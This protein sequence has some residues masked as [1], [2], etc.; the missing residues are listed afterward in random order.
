MNQ[1]QYIQSLHKSGKRFVIISALLMLAVPL[2]FSIVYNAWPTTALMI[3]GFMSVGA[4]YIPIGIIETYN[5]APMMGIGATYIA[6][7]TGNMANMKLPAALTAIKLAK[8]ES[9]SD[10]AEIIATLAVAT[11]SIV[12]TI[13]III[14]VLVLLP[15]LGAIQVFLGPVTDY[16]VPAIFGAL[17]VVFVVRNWQLTIAPF[18]AMMLLFT[19]VIKSPTVQPALVPVAS[20][21]SIG[22]ARLLFKKGWIKK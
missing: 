5:Y 4:I 22:V 10:E 14:G 6:N 13:I 12:T 9:G 17:G 18:V 8:V 20:L 21:I 2:T 1:E 19:F 15:Y 11:S 3:S 16:L 7:I